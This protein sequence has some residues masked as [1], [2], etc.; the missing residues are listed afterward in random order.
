MG[1]TQKSADQPR[2]ADS[3]RGRHHGWM[4]V[5]LRRVGLLLL[6]LI[7]IGAGGVLLRGQSE[8][9]G[10]QGETG[11]PGTA[12]S[13]RYAYQTSGVVLL[14][15][16]GVPQSGG[17]PTAFAAV[18][19]LTLDG[20]GG[21]AAVETAAIGTQRLRRTLQGG[22]DLRADCTGT[23]RIPGFDLAVDEIT[24]VVAARGSDLLLLSVTPTGSFT[25]RGTRQ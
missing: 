10:A 12:L 6:C 14:G 16:G 1:N 23:V 20:R 17:T 13:G 4:P 24:L 22:Y 18:G 7:L 5:R 3:D 2:L 15:A 11:C 21:F 19:V 25:G 8:R 9:A